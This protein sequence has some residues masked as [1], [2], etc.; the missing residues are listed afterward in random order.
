MMPM[1]TESSP[2]KV[3]HLITGLGGGGAERQLLHL[4]RDPHPEIQH[5]VIALTE[6]GALKS[7]FEE[8]GVLLRTLGMTPG[9]FSLKAFKRLGALIKEA[10]PAVLQTWLYHADLMGLI[11]SRVYGIPRLYWNLRCS[12]MQLERYSLATRLVVK[13]NSLLSP[14]PDGIVFNAYAGQQAHQKLGYRPKAWQYMPNGFVIPE[15][16]EV[17]I[18][19]G[20]GADTDTN[21]HT[22]VSTSLSEDPLS[23]A[24]FQE[25][26][27]KAK[28]AIR[29]KLNI[30]PH[31]LV[32]AMVARVDPMKDHDTFLAAGASL[33]HRFPILHLILIGKGTEAYH[34]SLKNTAHGDQDAT[35]GRLHTLGFRADAAELMKA[36]DAIVLASFG[37]G[38]PNVLGE[39]MAQGIPVFSSDV[40]D[41]RLLIEDPNFLFP[42]GERAALEN[43]L[44]LFFEKTASERDALGYAF[45]T[46]IRDTYSVETMRAR[47]RNFYTSS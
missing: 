10:R 31:S 40:G 9:R 27:Q 42:S 45:Q 11:A 37:E 24:D 7:D 34:K 17:G 3:L 28:A 41:A 22:N 23:F 5:Q 35:K 14:L 12:D 46:K 1:Q 18:D 47:Y 4:C 21:A 36:C 32:I 43:A 2:I 25:R 6:G 39:A 19:S 38:F 16:T 20:R 13:L 30:P 29:Q 26:T 44:T 8:A 33:Q 15:D